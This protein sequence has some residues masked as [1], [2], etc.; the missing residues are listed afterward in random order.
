MF[1]LGILSNFIFVFFGFSSHIL[2]LEKIKIKDVRISLSIIIYL[3]FL[4][5]NILYSTVSIICINSL[6]K[7]SEDSKEFSFEEN[8]E[9]NIHKKM[10]RKLRIKRY[11]VYLAVFVMLVYI[12]AI[13]FKD[14]Q[15]FQT[16]AKPKSIGVNTNKLFSKPTGKENK[17][18]LSNKYKTNQ[19]L[20][21]L[22]FILDWVIFILPFILYVLNVLLNLT[23]YSDMIY[24]QENLTTIIDRE[25]FEPNNEETILMIE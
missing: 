16:L 22:N 5:F 7:Q 20:N 1:I 9:N 17:N 12:G 10:R 4:F 23:Y 19:K 3:S 6:T 24:I 21:K 15:G 18:S 8:K 2:K 14:T 13:V 25:Y 11:V